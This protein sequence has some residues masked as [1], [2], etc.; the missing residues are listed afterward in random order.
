MLRGEPEPVPQRDYVYLEHGLWSA[1]RAIR[2]IGAPD[3]RDWKLIKSYHGGLLNW[4]LT[5]LFDLANDPREECNAAKD[6]PELVRDLQ[7]RLWQ[8]EEEQLQGWPD[9]PEEG[10]PR[11]PANGRERAAKHAAR[12]LAVAS[13]GGPRSTDGASSEIT[14]AQCGQGQQDLLEKRQ[15]DEEYGIGQREPVKYCSRL[16]SKYSV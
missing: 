11:R 5:Q 7:Y 2:T 14:R 4:P 12:R 16:S 10:R 8:W 3:G 13:R 15:R 1:Q 9:P 6:H